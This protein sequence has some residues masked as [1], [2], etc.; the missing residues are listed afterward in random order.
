MVGLVAG[1]LHDYEG[2]RLHPAAVTASTAVLFSAVHW[3]ARLLVAGTF[4]LALV[5]VTAYL[6]RRNLWALGL[7]HG[8]IGGCF[9]FFVLGRDP[10]QEV[11]VAGSRFNIF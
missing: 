3:P 5:Y 11:F 9:Y 1:N 4:V 2:R 6:R 8:W 10:W 7:Y